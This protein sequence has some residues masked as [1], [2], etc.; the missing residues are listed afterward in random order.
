MPKGVKKQKDYAVI[1]S[2]QFVR[3][4]RHDSTWNMQQQRCYYFLA[5]LIK[6]NDEP[7]HI[8]HFKADYMRKSLGMSESGTNYADIKE[9]L[10]ALRDNSQWI[11]NER[12]NL[13][14]VSI[15]QSVQVSEET[16]ETE[17]QFHRLIQPH[18]F[19]LQS[20]YTRESLGTLFA[21]DC[22]YTPELYLFLLSYF[23]ENHQE[24]MEK[25]V[26][27]KEIKERL[28]CQY[29]RWIDIKRF[30][31]DKAVHEINNY[32]NCMRVSYEPVSVKKKVESLIFHMEQPTD[33]DAAFTIQQLKAQELWKQKHKQGKQTKETRQRKAAIKQAKRKKTQE[34]K[35][36]ISYIDSLLAHEIMQSDEQGRKSLENLKDTLLRIQGLE[37]E[38][39]GKHDTP[40]PGSAAAQAEG[41]ETK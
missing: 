26:S 1:Q 9:I 22:K 38:I 19:N 41:S 35:Q 6:P 7:D 14:V 12:G 16:G 30:V 37:Q 33:A 29:D 40:A 10:K 31:I 36:V 15:L 8:Y 5:S 24:E 23:N 21:F 4:F 3:Y 18:L 28:S 17:I 2:N 39:E 20:R 25:A 32:S 27:L 34:E 13:E 11:R